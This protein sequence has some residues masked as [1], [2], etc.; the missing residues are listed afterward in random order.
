[1][2][3]LGFKDY[4]LD[5]LKNDLDVENLKTSQILNDTD[6]F[7][8]KTG[9]LNSL[10]ILFLSLLLAFNGVCSHSCSTG[11]TGVAGAAAESGTDETTVF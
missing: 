8:A 5:V 2:V 10:S 4:L 9:T 7:K 3:K 11:A 1:M 6:N